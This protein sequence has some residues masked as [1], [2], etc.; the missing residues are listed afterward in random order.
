MLGSQGKSDDDTTL[1]PPGVCVS[2]WGR[3]GEACHSLWQ[4]AGCFK[5]KRRVCPG[6]RTTDHPSRYCTSHYMFTFQWW[7][8]LKRYNWKTRLNMGWASVSHKEFGDLTCWVSLR[9]LSLVWWR[10]KGWECCYH[11][12]K[13][14]FPYQK[15]H[16]SLMIFIDTGPSDSLVNCVYFYILFQQNT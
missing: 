11:A 14:P 9:M 5:A 3:S 10:Q 12:G 8:G 13:K 16:A 2:P 6:W 15:V 1:W 4:N 7:L